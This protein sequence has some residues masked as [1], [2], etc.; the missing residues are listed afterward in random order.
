MLV[1]GTRSREFEPR[2]PHVKI[3]KICAKCGVD[4]EHNVSPSGKRSSYCIECQREYSRN[5]H[6]AT[7]G[8]EHNVT[9]RR[10]NRVARRD[11]NL[12]IIRSAKDVP[13]TDCDTRFP[14]YVM[15]F[16]HLDP[17]DKLADIGREARQWSAAKLQAE[18][19]KCEVVCSNCHRIR[20]FNRAQ[21]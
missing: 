7:K 21:A 6:A 5:H 12:Q 13:C 8:T 10:T 17:T 9:R 14:Y 1:L 18:I 2:L 4:S 15:D 20:T 16:D 3:M 11:R 19:D